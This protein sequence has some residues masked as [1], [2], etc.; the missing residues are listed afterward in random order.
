V[1][2]EVFSFSLLQRRWSASRAGRIA[3]NS[4]NFVRIEIEPVRI[5]TLKEIPEVSGREA[6]HSNFTGWVYAADSA[7]WRNS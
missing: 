5:Y 4:R 6:N 7:R 2:G 1:T 3:R